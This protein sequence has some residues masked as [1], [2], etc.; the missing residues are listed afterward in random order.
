[1]RIYPHIV[2][3]ECDG[4]EF[5][6]KIKILLVLLL[7]GVIVYAAPLSV[8]T[9]APAK[10]LMPWQQFF[11]ACAARLGQR[12]SGK[13]ESADK[14][15]AAAAELPSVGTD[16]G[17]E[18]AAVPR[19][20]RVLLTHNQDGNHMFGRMRISCNKSWQ[21]GENKYG[22]ADVLTMD[23]ELITGEY[24]RVSSDDAD[25]EFFLEYDGLERR[26]TRYRGALYFYP[27]ADGFY[28]VN[29]LPLETYVAYTVPGEM[30]ASYPAE[31]LKAQAVCSRT[32]AVKNMGGMEDYHAD[33]DDS[34]SWQV[35][36]G[37]DTDERAAEAV[38]ATEGE[39]LLWKGKPA[40][41]YF[42]STSCGLTSRKDIWDSGDEENC[43]KAAYVGTEG[44]MPES[45]EA[46]ATYIQ[47]DDENAWEH[48][49][50]WFRWRVTM[51]L[52]RIQ[53]LSER[54]KSGL[55]SVLSLAVTSRSTGWA[56]T[57]LTVACEKGSY[58]V[59]SEYAIRSFLSPEGRKLKNKEGKV[60]SLK[61]L[62]SGYFVL[63][64]Y[65]DDEGALAGYRIRGGGL[66]HGAGL[67]QNGAKAMAEQGMD[68]RQILELFYQD[69]VLANGER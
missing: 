24:F 36:N 4:M 32:Y 38:K 56:A 60:S 18:D 68:Y 40:D 51:P 59:E 15:E 10:P 22:R 13:G 64:P 35:Y 54:K 30:P 25:A 29:E 34:V 48:D 45:E 27:A 11:L 53:E 47:A 50:P 57:E 26:S 69:V 14:V 5:L 33:V 8:E 46:F 65:Y 39:I 67:S 28:V 66:G 49:M 55:G 52:S 37:Q 12:D 1:M 62:P 6:K 41:I 19:A 63:K 21:A 2:I 7:V 43:L 16:C 20:I 42:F 58:T 31:A 44:K 3:P 23:T 61:I 17:E 9:L